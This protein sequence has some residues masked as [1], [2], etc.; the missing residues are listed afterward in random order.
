[1]KRKRPYS[2]RQLEGTGTPTGEVDTGFPEFEPDYVP[3]LY[4]FGRDRDSR[5]AK[6]EEG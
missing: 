2:F 5:V 1:M 4:A 6:G 3:I